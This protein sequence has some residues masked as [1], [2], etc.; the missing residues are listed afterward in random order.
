MAPVRTL[1]EKVIDI[2]TTYEQF[3]E[4]LTPPIKRQVLWDMT[5]AQQ[6]SAAEAGD[7]QAYAALVNASLQLDRVIAAND[8]AALIAAVMANSGATRIP[9]DVIE[10]GVE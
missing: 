5:N 4:M 10:G 2:K 6:Q 3:A 1:S 8:R 7:V 9:F